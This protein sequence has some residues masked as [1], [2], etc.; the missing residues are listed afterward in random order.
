FNPFQGIHYFADYFEMRR[1][2]SGQNRKIEQKFTAIYTLFLLQSL[3]FLYQYFRDFTPLEVIIHGDYMRLIYA[4]EGYFGLIG[5]CA[6]SAY[7]FKRM[8][9]NQ[10]EL[11]QLLFYILIQGKGGFFRFG[12][13][14]KS[15]KY[16]KHI[17]SL[18]LIYHAALQLFIPIIGNYY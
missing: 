3:H 5:V 13:R 18:C 12:K 15:A 16:C 10:T 8:Y 17:R 2:L 7:F 14:Q 9:F 4:P 11:W 1:Q 6:F